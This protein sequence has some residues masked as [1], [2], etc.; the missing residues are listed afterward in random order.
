MCDERP[1]RYVHNTL[2]AQQHS[3]AV[4]TWEHQL[5]EQQGQGQGQG[6]RHATRWFPRMSIWWQVMGYACP[7]TFRDCGTRREVDDGRT[8]DMMYGQYEAQRYPA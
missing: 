3:L 5:A 2:L 6:Q 8:C 7:A 1:R 4:H